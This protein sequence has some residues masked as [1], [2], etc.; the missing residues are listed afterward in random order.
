MKTKIG[1][2]AIGALCLA[3]ALAPCANA[4][5]TGKNNPII[6]ADKGKSDYRIV[7]PAAATDVEKYAAKELQSFL[8]QISGAQIGIATDEGAMSESEILLGR[9]AHLG[10]L[11]VNIDF[12]ALGR[13]GFTI[14]THGKNLIIAGNTGRGTMYGVYTFLEDHLGCRWYSSK[15]S[16]IPKIATIRL[17]E[18]ADTQVPVLDYREVYYY[19]AMDPAFAGRLKLNGNASKIENGKMVIERHAGWSTWCHTSFTFVPPKKYFKEHPEYYSLQKDGRKA[20]QLCF[21]NPELVD[22]TVAKI[23]DLLKHPIDFAPHTSKVVSREGGPI[24][25]RGED[26][27]IDVSQMDGGGRC[28][29]PK[30]KAV[31]ER[32][33][34]PIGSI[35]TFVNKVAAHF[36]DKTIS[37]LA[38]FYSQRP[39]KHIKPAPNVSIMLC[40]YGSSRTFP[41]VSSPFAGD[42]RFMRDIEKWS[43]ISRHL[44][45]WDYVVN[46]RNLYMPN[47]NLHIQ[48]PNIKFYIDHHVKGIFEQASREVGGEFCELRNY[49]LAKLLW[50]PDCDVDAVMNDFLNGYYGP[51]GKPI[52]RYIDLMRETVAANKINIGIYS[53]PKSYTKSFLS[54]EML[55]KYNAFFDEAE[56]LVAG[57]PDLT[58]RVR[59]ARMPLMFVELVNG[60]GSAAKRMK[61][62][63]EFTDLCARNGVR[64]LSE[65]GNSPEHFRAT[66]LDRLRLELGVTFSPPGGA[67]PDFNN[68]T[69]KMSTVQK[70]AKIHYT[71]DGSQPTKDS[72][73]YTGPVKITGPCTVRAVAMGKIKNPVVSAR[74]IKAKLPTTSGPKKKSDPAEHLKLP[75]S[76]VKQLR[77]IVT[78]AGDSNAHDHA[79]W[80][81]A[82]L[83]A[84]D[85]KVTYLSDLKPIHHSQDWGRLGIDKSVGGQPLQIGVKKFR[86]GL[87]THSNSEIVY[88]LDGKYKYFESYIG[89]DAEA[90]SPASVVFKVEGE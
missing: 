48:Q 86:K 30:C 51:G 24:W 34:S 11:G 5:T 87:G 61:T 38:Y 65:G 6:L 80:A 74:F 63:D 71:M 37:T 20:R 75:V 22:I 57:D 64:R 1:S 59:T 70:N 28:Q 17:P 66:Q 33:G 25:A 68:L 83:I 45:I 73:L 7:I 23:R 8:K 77:L 49:L 14:R 18:I 55:A 36:P 13:E 78:D 43:K 58:F 2:A 46:F 35:L 88:R 29:C 3:T 69:V 72:P 16:R 19:D 31:D 82:K 53:S 56:R 32:E 40:N 67:F 21:T 62:L 81:D 12:N 54:E 76:G 85:G 39:P 50:N 9:N 84:P 26:V 41:F 10:K 52:R 60:Y 4:S 44:L 47:P 89:V 27:Y 42:K 90:G 15:V 79:D